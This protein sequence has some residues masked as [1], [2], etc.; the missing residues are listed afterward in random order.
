MR[1]PANLLLFFAAQFQKYLLSQARATKREPALQLKDLFFFQ[2]E[3]GIRDDLVTGV[4]TCA[5][6]ISNHLREPT[7]L[8]T[9]FQNSA[10]YK[11]YRSSLS[12]APDAPG[13][14]SI[15]TSDCC[16]CAY[17]AA[18]QTCEGTI[19][20]LRNDITQSASTIRNTCSFDR[21]TWRRS[22]RH[23]GFG[24]DSSPRY[25][26]NGAIRVGCS[27]RCPQ[28][29]IFPCAEDSARYTSAAKISARSLCISLVGC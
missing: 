20:I 23:S 9:H 19:R 8:R 27:V 6:P 22:R 29:R 18:E 25:V 4:Q 2:A 10:A 5:L 21:T 14:F 12:H 13:E 7:S 26:S 15:E 3:D 17:C 16:G 1:T 28:R 24:R 11:R